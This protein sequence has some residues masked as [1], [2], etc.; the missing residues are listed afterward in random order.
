L[1]ARC[2]ERI[3]RKVE[4][5]WRGDHYEPCL[6]QDAG[7]SLPPPLAH[8]EVAGFDLGEAHIA[9]VTT[10]RRHALILSG[11]ALRPYKQG[12]N[13]TH[14]AL[15]AKLSRCQPDSLRAK[16]LRWPKA[17]ISAKLYW[18]QREILHQAA[19]KVTAFC[20]TEGVLRIV[21]GDV[22]DIQTGVR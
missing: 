11:R 13:N 12:R 5:T 16:R 19:R 4:L 20:Q 17:K 8:G 15:D 2:Q 10:T 22:R 21:V 6:T 7:Q 1:P 3:L 14:A 18:R 9:A